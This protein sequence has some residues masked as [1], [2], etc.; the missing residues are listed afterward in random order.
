MHISRPYAT[1]CACSLTCKYTSFFLP[2]KKIFLFLFRQT[3]LDSGEKH[4]KD[5]S[6]KFPYGNLKKAEKATSL[7]MDYQTA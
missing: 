7:K 4:N 2:P 6:Q 5:T 1:I 3:S